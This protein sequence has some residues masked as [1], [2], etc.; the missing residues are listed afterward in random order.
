MHGT[1]CIG[2]SAEFINEG[3]FLASEI[4][5]EVF[6]TILETGTDE[7]GRRHLKARYAKLSLEERQLR[8]VRLAE[9]S[10]FVMRPDGTLDYGLEP[11]RKTNFIK[12]LFHLRQ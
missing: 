11:K 9:Y 12:K 10:G 1:E 4:D 8:E 6:D 5:R 7:K 3:D 2:E